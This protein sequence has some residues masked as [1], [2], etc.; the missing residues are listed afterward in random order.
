MRER[1]GGGMKDSRGKVSRALAK[2]VHSAKWAIAELVAIGMTDG[3]IDLY[4]RL[5]LLVQDEQ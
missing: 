2:H 3:S 1:D 5:Q 4:F